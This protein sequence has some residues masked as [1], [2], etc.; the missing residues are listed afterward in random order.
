MADTT[1][2]GTWGTADAVTPGFGCKTAGSSPFTTG[3]CVHA[4]NKIAV[5]ASSAAMRDAL[6]GSRSGRRNEV[7]GTLMFPFKLEEVVITAGRAVRVFPTYC[8]ASFVNRAAAFGLIEKHAHRLVHRVFAVTQY[9]H[10]FTFVHDLFGK[11][12]TCDIHCQTVMFG[13][14]CDVGRFR[15]YVVVTTA[16]SGALGAVV[17]IFGCHDAHL[18][19]FDRDSKGLARS[20][21]NELL[22]YLRKSD[23][24]L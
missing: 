24:V 6:I 15:F 7:V 14:P 11:F 19:L 17:R 22:K 4:D 1:G 2:G 20:R 21:H 10:S 16:I 18:N 8:G 23:G 5:A 12:F 9:A 3:A 13:Q